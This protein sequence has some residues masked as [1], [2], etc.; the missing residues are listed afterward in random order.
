MY[1]ACVASKRPAG[2]S[3]KQ[4]LTTGLDFCSMLTL[5]HNIEEQHIFPLLG[6]KMPLFQKQD[7]L[8]AQHKQ[9][10]AGLE[11][12]EKYLAECRVGEREL[13]LEEL[14]NVMDGFGTILWA[15]LDEEV[16]QLGAENMRKF[17]SLEEMKR[18]PM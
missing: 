14:K 8:V 11:K 15:H 18:M 10:H 7:T 9:I 13:R 17:W 5:H 4:F 12:L 3:I 1:D 16:G 6:R 2:M